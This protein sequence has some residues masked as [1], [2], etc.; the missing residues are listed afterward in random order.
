MSMPSAIW[1]CRRAARLEGGVLLVPA[2][3]GVAEHVVVRE[4]GRDLP[5]EQL[6]VAALRCLQPS[7]MPSPARSWAWMSASVRCRSGE[8]VDPSRTRFWS[9]RSEHQRLVLQL[10]HLV[11]D[12]LQRAGGGEQVLL[13]VGGIEHGQ[14]GGRPRHAA[15]EHRRRRS[16]AA[17]E[18]CASALIAA[19][20]R[21]AWTRH[22]TAR[23][24]RAWAV[25]RGDQAAARRRCGVDS[26]RRCLRRRW[27]AVRGGGGRRGHTFGR[28]D[29][30][31]CLRNAVAA[32]PV[33]ASARS[34]RPPRRGPWPQEPA[35][36]TR[37][38]RLRP[39]SGRSAADRPA[40]EA[41]HKAS[42]TGPSPSSNRRL[43]RAVWA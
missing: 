26:P 35:R 41:P 27:P 24:A 31:G 10:A 40:I 4:G 33:A 22:G 2:G 1:P 36:R 42:A 14:L 43:P 7:A 11:V 19:P 16:A 37:P 25:R 12:L 8:I 9:M 13:V 38:A 3:L 21:F 5:R 6:L 23:G 18:S 30:G 15:G 29:R 28:I 39:R 34:A 20:L 17:S 32:L